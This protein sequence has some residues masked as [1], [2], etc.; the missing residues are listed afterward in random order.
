[1]ADGSATGPLAGLR[2]VEFCSIGPGPHAAMLLSD[3]GA[4]VLRIDRPG[5]NGW[6]NPIVDRGRHTLVLDIRSEEARPTVLEATD[7]ADVLIEGNRPGVMERL[8][9]GPDALIERNARL[10]FARIT[11]WGQTGP[12]ARSAGHDINY[13][14]LTGALAAITG[15]DGLPIPPLNLVGDFGGGSICLAFGIVA[16]LWER[17]RS[18]RGQVVDAA[19]ID[20]VSSMM[21]MFSGLL[22]N[23]RISLERDHNVLGGRAPFYR[24]YVC[25]DGKHVSVGPLEPQFYALLL[26]KIGAPDDLRAGQYDAA[27][28]EERG[29]RLAALFRERTRQEWCALLEGSDA[30]FAPVL[31]YAES[32]AHPQM[33]A[34]CSYV[35]TNGLRQAAPQPRFSR[36]PGAIGSSGDGAALLERWSRGPTSLR[37]SS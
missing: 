34:R 12:L 7:R 13:I 37:D 29:R 36:T 16:A 18:G 9:Y 4:D 19:I 11:G 31:T 23:E 20:G 28:W 5:G 33:I 2:V 21:T 30:C 32:L 25:A 3:L 24:C 1:M 14:A 17:E 15:E 6:P 27:G 26:E 22:A 35:E 10:I 8:G